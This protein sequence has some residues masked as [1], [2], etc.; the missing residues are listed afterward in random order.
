MEMKVTVVVEGLSELS[1]SIALLASAIG[2]GKGA[3]QLVEMA[4][5]T[6]QVKADTPQTSEKAPE[7]PKADKPKAPPKDAKKSEPA[8]P[9]EPEEQPFEPDPVPEASEA[10][11]YKLEEVRAK[12]ADLSKAGKSAEVKKIIADCGADKLSDVDPSKYADLMAK[13]GTL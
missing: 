13:A 11:Q 12:L 8:P 7:A 4:K 2:Y 5:A 10:K 9:E 6:E 1:S 3:A